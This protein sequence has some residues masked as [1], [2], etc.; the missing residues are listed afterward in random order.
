M[1]TSV[2]EGMYTE[3]DSAGTPIQGIRDTNDFIHSG[4]IKGLSAGI[5]GHYAIKNGAYNGSVGFEIVQGNS[6]GKTTLAV[7][8][9]KVFRD[10]AY[11]S[12]ATVTFTANSS[13]S[14]FDEPSSGISYF[15]IVADASNVLKIRGDKANVNSLPVNKHTSSSATD[16]LTGDV[17][18]AIVKMANGGTVDARP[19]QF[20]TT[21]QDEKTV[22]IGHTTTNAF[23]EAMSISSTASATTFE[24]KVSD[25]DIVFQVK[26]GSSA[27]QEVLRLDASSQRVGIN[28]A[29]PS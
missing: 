7:A 23:V 2:N 13:P 1:V 22:T 3:M 27:S 15:M 6:G 29:T 5:R 24:N 19:I 14:T 26:D 8:A 16:I 18:I 25:A 12:V 21:D 9:G 4:I 11:N 20:L 10:G 17:P 28:A